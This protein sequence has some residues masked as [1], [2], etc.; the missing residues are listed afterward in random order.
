MTIRKPRLKVGSMKWSLLVLAW[1]LAL[2]PQRAPAQ[3]STPDAIVL[4]QTV[5]LVAIPQP[6]RLIGTI[7]PRVETDIAFRVGGKM[8]RR[9]VDTGQIVQAGQ[10]LAELDRTDLDL[11]HRQAEADY[12]A[13]Q[14][15]QDM[16]QAEYARTLT[17]R[18]SG[19]STQAELDRHHAAA[20]EAA[21]RLIRAGHTRTLAQHALEYATLR[22][23]APG[24]VITA[25]AEPGQVLASGQA[26]LR[27]AYLDRLEAEV[28]VP[29]SLLD[30]VRIAAAAVSLWALPGQDFPVLLREISVRADPAT[31]TYPARFTLPEHAPGVAL[32]MTATVTLTR[33]GLRGVV[34]A[35]SA[36]RDDGA[37]PTVF[38]LDQG[39]TV[40][41]QRPVTLARIGADNVAIT[42]GL[43]E[44]E[45]VVLLGVQKLI[46]GL[47]VR[48]VTRLPS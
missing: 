14:A 27:I 32:G 4:V 2:A 12:T 3:P 24:I 19:W 43:A 18:Q 15:G 21:G 47:R 40:L 29:E 23:S 22:A 6:H 13:A 28:A 34:L 25:I 45:Q 39:G 11:Q 44:G 26:A 48:P 20:E 16:T 8:I 17:L 10:I 30:T 35:L 38:V 9:H 41:Q 31:R 5:H 37:G 1:L 7:R 33:P 46:P 36:I 42:S